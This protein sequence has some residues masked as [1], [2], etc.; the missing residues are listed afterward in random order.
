M[1][2]NV[3]GTSGS[4]KSTVAKRISKKLDIPY[5]ELDCV[6]WGPNWYC[7]PDAVFFGNLEKELNQ[8]DWVLDGNY[9]RTEHLKWQDVDFV[10]WVDLPFYLTFYQATTRAIKRASSKQELWPNTNNRES[11]KKSFFSKDSIIMWTV[12]T[13]TKNKRKYERYL[14]DDA[15]S[16][17]NFI[18]LK[19]RKE[20]NRFVRDLSHPR[21]N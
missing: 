4:G 20:I 3:V 6:F 2:I 21:S 10:V 18:R 9:T 7:P 11:F 14:S 8:A 19:S 1:K 15:F 16:H 17:I 13:Y 5:I 12:K